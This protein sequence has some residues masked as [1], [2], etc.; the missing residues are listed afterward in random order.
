M[1]TNLYESVVFPWEKN[2][3]NDKIPD[4]YLFQLLSFG[5]ITLFIQ[6]KISY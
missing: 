1:T 5:N 6:Q 4:S 3:K 2:V